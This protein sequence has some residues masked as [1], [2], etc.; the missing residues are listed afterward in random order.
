VKYS[1][2]LVIDFKAAPATL[3][4]LFDALELM[5]CDIVGVAH[6]GQSHCSAVCR[7]T[8]TR[9]RFSLPRTLPVVITGL[10]GLQAQWQI[11]HPSGGLHI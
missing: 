8:K 9:V 7:R 4:L 3:L 6:R 10:W 5:E 2:F 11:E 1:S